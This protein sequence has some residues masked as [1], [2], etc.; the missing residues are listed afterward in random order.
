V[1]ELVPEEE[2]GGDPPCWAAQFADEEGEDEEEEGPA[3]QDPE[4]PPTR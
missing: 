4:T 1:S 3:G 2:Q